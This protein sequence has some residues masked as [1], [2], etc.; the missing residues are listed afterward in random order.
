MNPRTQWDPKQ[1]KQ[2][3]FHPEKT[4]AELKQGLEAAEKLGNMYTAQLFQDA[5][6]RLNKTIRNKVD[7]R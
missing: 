1:L 2:D 4:L 6:D 5:I 3:I 7:R